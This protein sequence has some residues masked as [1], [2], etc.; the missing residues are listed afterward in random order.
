MKI[1]HIVVAV[2]LLALMLAIARDEIGRV[3]LVI[4]LTAMGAVVIGTSSIMMLFRTIGEFGAA[5]SLVSHI[6]AL[7]AT[8]GVLVF[9]G[10][11]MLAVLWCGAAVVRSVVK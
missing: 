10:G 8:A 6:E 11:S 2:L 1:W 4:F 3:A 9:G 5:R 7:F